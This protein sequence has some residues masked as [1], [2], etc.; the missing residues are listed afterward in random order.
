MT[1]SMT[2]WRA[3]STASSAERVVSAHRILRRRV[4]HCRRWPRPPPRS[5]QNSSKGTSRGS[6]APETRA[7]TRDPASRPRPTFFRFFCLRFLLGFSDSWFL[8]FFYS[9]ILLFFY[10][11]RFFS[12]SF[13]QFSLVFSFDFFFRSPQRAQSRPRWSFWIGKT[14]EGPDESDGPDGPDGPMGP[15]TR[16]HADKRTRDPD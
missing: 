7:Y 4:D 10:S 14:R 3:R 8:L 6:T 12:F 1:V 11:F 5:Q 16:G 13:G 2:A 9:F 15:M